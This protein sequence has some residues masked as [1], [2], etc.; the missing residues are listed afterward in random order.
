MR[1]ILLIGLMIAGAGCATV[2]V[3]VS[4]DDVSALA[5][6]WQ[7]WLITDGGVSLISFDIRADGTFQVSGPLV[8]ASGVLVVADG[9]LRFDGTGMW[10]GTLVPEGTG[11]RRVLRIQ[12]DDRLYRGTL[13]PISH[14]GLDPGRRIAGPRTSRA[15]T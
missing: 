5:G 3:S 6:S 7:G 10:R 15:R 1:V 2:P 11:E 8:R 9:A 13:H 14:G 4:P 12:R